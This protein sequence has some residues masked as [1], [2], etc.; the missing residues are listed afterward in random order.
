MPRS[1][2]SPSRTLMTTAT[3]P[4]TTFRTRTFLGTRF[5]SSPRRTIKSAQE[6]S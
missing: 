4:T 3:T 2:T 1:M 6:Q 5:S